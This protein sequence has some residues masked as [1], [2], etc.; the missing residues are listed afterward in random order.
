MFCN[1]AMS[2]AENRKKG[3]MKF[4]FEKKM[5][6]TALAQS[7]NEYSCNINLYLSIRTVG[8]NYT[9]WRMVVGFMFQHEMCIDK[10]CKKY[11]TYT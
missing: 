4:N 8:S 11:A 3:F 1:F 5:N 6:P 10:V 7:L 9:D 2:C